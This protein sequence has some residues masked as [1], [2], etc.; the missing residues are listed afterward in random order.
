VE[1]ND[2]ASICLLAHDYNLGRAG[3]QQDKTKAIKLY[4]RAA[5]LGNIKAHNNLAGIYFEGGN[6]KKTKFHFEVA[7]MAED[8]ALRYNLGTM[9]VNSGNMERAV[10]HWTIAASAGDYKAMQHLKICF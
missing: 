6:L 7:A 5:D 2:A 9:E 1:A 8:E 3:F 10:K 4:V